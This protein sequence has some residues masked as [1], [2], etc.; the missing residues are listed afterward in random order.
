MNAKL[1]LPSDFDSS[2]KIKYPVLFHPYGGPNS[3]S[4][5]QIY[6]M[7]FDEL[8]ASLGIIIV[9]VDGRGTG[10]RGREYRSCISHRLGILEALDQIAAAKYSFS[11]FK[12]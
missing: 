11:F 6:S 12:I 3:Q 8:L 2:G 1:I 10:F 7:G 5:N 4:V 9:I